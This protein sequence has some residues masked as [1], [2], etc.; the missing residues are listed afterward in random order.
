MH[1][2]W[3][4]IATVDGDALTSNDL[5]LRLKTYGG[6]RN[7]TEGD[8]REMVRAWIAKQVL[9]GEAVRR[10][11][12]LAEGDEREV[13]GVLVAWLASH[14]ATADSFF[15]EGPLPEEVKRNDFKE[16]LLVHALVREVLDKESFAEF[17]RSLHEKALV[18][19]PEFPDLEP[20]F[21]ALVVSGG[22]TNI[23]RVDDYNSCITLGQTRDDAA[24][25]AY[26]KVARVL[27]L[28]YPGGPL[29]DELARSGDPEAVTFKRVFLEDGSLD[30]SFSGIK[31]GV[32]NYVN[33]ERQAGREINFADVA[34]SFQEAVL[35]VIVTKSVGA[36]VDNNE[37][38]LVVAGGVAAN[39]RLREKLSEACG[40]EGI[41][42]CVPPAVLCT[43]NAAMI[44]AAGYYKYISEGPDDLSLDAVAQLP[45]G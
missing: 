30:F 7:V 23:V 38:K 26:D 24:G 9:L 42:L 32:M 6:G 44:G 10:N 18:R 16:G 20:P 41:R 34:A 3:R 14:G 12:S 8:R 27:G 11:V 40:R 15:A 35:D 25:E 1:R 29:I 19:C 17:Y 2:P 39:G 21:M 36:A 43:D 22:H 13:K 45:L 33:S 28:G 37:D 31:T 4:V 5:D